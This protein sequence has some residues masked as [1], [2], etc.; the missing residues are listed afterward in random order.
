MGFPSPA[1]PLTMLIE[2]FADDMVVWAPAKVNLHLELLA[3]RPDGYHE[4]E[5]LM[6]AVNLCDTLVFQDDPSGLLSLTC[7][8]AEL[9]TGPDN[10][11]LRA[12]ELL[13][14]TANCKR[15]ARIRLVKRI[16]LAAGLA[17]GSTDAAATLAGLNALWNLGFDKPRLALLSGRLGSDVAFFWHTPAA[18]CTGRGEI[19]T[20]V[21]M[22]KR[23][24]LVLVCPPFGLA[25]AEVYRKVTV[26]AVPRRGDA[27]RQALTAG[28]VEQV[29]R[30]LHNRLQPAAEAIQPA[31][32]D[33]QRRL[34]ELKPAGARMSG[35]GSSLFAVCRDRPEAL[36]IAHQLRS[37]AD[38]RMSLKGTVYL[39]RTCS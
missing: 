10:L 28:D 37:G 38:R 25:T 33:Y 39:V 17:G 4:L 32:A 12:A 31:V 21:R 14:Q 29:G 13:R 22:K 9:S 20:P 16:P 18:W 34:D 11:V 36:A 15:G 19:V 24:W 1:A 3:K 2:R 8:R 7:N 23:L 6:I 27:I 26:P 35:S 30:C 5:T